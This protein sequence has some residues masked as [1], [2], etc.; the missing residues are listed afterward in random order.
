MSDIRTERW[1]FDPWEGPADP[2][3]LPKIWSIKP[4]YLVDGGRSC[5]ELAVL[6]RLR[7]DGWDGVWV[8]AFGRFLRR[9]WFGTADAFKTITAVGAPAGVAA[10]FERLREA[11]GGLAGFWD[12][13][14]WRDGDVKFVEAKVGADRLQKTQLRFMELALSLGHTPEQ[15]LLVEVNP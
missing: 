3:D 7:H 10:V 12:V 8:S 11:N 14:A 15:F 6:A 1:T 9:D 4:K 2:P 13:F 5:A